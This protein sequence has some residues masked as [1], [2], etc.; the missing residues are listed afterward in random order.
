MFTVFPFHKAGPC[1]LV[2]LS[3]CLSVVCGLSVLDNFE[4]C[5]WST[6]LSLVIRMIRK[7][8]WSLPLVVL[9][10]VQDGATG[11]VRL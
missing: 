1:L 11:L 8:C 4:A 9:S 3:V 6:R 7:L 2:D 5:D 10:L